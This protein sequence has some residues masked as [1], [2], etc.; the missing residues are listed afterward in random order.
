MVEAP[1]PPQHQVAVPPERT[2]VFA[3]STTTSSPVGLSKYFPGLRRNPAD[4]PRF[5]A[6][7]RFSWFGLRPKGNT[8]VYETDARVALNRPTPEPTALPVALQVPTDRAV[9]P[10]SAETILPASPMQP[11]ASPAN[12]SQP[13]GSDPLAVGPAQVPDFGGTPSKPGEDE[14][15]PL[16][17]AAEPGTPAAVAYRMP[18]LPAIDPRERPQLANPQPSEPNPAPNPAPEPVFGQTADNKAVKAITRP[19]DPFQASGSSEAMLPASYSTHHHS[20]KAQKTTVY[21]SPQGAPS[22]TPTPPAK[23]APQAK[24]TSPGLASPQSCEETTCQY[25]KWK[26]PCF[27]RLFR[28]IFKQGEYATPPVTMAH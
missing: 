26:K 17:P 21:A 11:S 25:H 6:T 15:N 13:G 22:P 27:C 18:E 28:K 9:R 20:E 10:T 19:T 12:P 3:Q 23:P 4:S 2:D 24:P 8:Q 14:V 7:S 5:A 1:A 16:P